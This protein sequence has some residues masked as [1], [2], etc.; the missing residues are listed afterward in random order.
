MKGDDNNSSSQI[1][2]VLSNNGVINFKKFRATRIFKQQ[3][4]TSQDGDNVTFTISFEDYAG[5]QILVNSTTD[6]SIVKYDDRVPSLDP[7]SITSDNKNSASFPVDKRLAMPNDNVTLSFT[8][9][10]DL[11]NISLN[12]AN[13]NVIPNLSGNNYTF[14]KLM[15]DNDINKSFYSDSSCGS[16]NRSTGCKIPFNIVAKDFAGNQSVHTEINTSDNSSVKFDGI[17]PT[18]TYINFRT[19]NCNIYAGKVGDTQK[20]SVIAS[21]PM[22]RDS[23]IVN[24][25]NGSDNFSN[26]T[27]QISI[28]YGG[29]TGDLL[30]NDN[31]TAERVFTNTD[32]EGDIKIYSY[33]TD[34]AGNSYQSDNTSDSSYV[35]FDRTIPVLDNISI[36]TNNDSGFDN[37][38]MSGHF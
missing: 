14:K 28:T 1:I 25:H 5:N 37:Y 10:E 27:G 20:L 11:D 31:F 35:I 7:I 30:S 19:D 13:E 17:D 4:I 12:F 22:L 38:S 33:L 21:E 2:Q 9:P 23:V 3:P 6:G 32:A 16:S 18:L 8:T 34:P 15:I 24:F 26:K 36:F 29:N